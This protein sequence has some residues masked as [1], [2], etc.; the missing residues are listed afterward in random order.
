ME[1]PIIPF[2][3]GSTQIILPENMADWVQN[4]DRL[5][6]ALAISLYN[7]PFIELEGW[8]LHSNRVRVAAWRRGNQCVIGCRGT[9]IGSQYGG[10]DLVDDTVRNRI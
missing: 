6:L 5:P 7:N 1:T 3:G 2:G 8:V 4:I 9:S 10:K